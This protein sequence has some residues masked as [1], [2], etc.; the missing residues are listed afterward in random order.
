MK[1]NTTASFIRSF[2]YV[3]TQAMR[4]K[5]IVK[6]MESMEKSVLELKECSGQYSVLI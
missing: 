2:N 1:I 4:G 6:T 5:I 3:F